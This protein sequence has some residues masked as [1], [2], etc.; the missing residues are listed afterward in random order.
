MSNLPKETG[1]DECAHSADFST[2]ERIASKIKQIRAKYW[3]ALEAERQ[4]EE[5][6]IVAIFYDL[7]SE[8]WSNSPGYITSSITSSVTSSVTPIQQNLPS[9][10]TPTQ[11]SSSEG[12]NKTSRGQTYREKMKEMLENRWN[13][14]IQRKLPTA[15][16]S[17]NSE[18]EKFRKNLPETME[19]QDNL[20]RESIQSLQENVRALPQIMNQGV[21]RNPPPFHYQTSNFRFAITSSF[22]CESKSQRNPNLGESSN[23]FERQVKSMV[24]LWKS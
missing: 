20:F 3:R 5:G 11:P 14:R 6:R 16:T 15:Q 1:S 19:R 24:A 23:I 21:H 8:K 9:T 12:S 7:C 2:R 10:S 17:T 13:K 18:E 22:S 4:S